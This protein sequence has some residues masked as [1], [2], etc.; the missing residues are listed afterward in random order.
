[1]THLKKTQEGPWRD[2]SDE[3]LRTLDNLEGDP[4]APLKP[5]GDC[6]SC[7][8]PD[9][10]F[11]RDP[12]PGWGRWEERPLAPGLMWIRCLGRRT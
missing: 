2:W 5:S 3:E 12:E 9:H 11:M 10:N 6:S 8:H 1:M 7:K 4:L